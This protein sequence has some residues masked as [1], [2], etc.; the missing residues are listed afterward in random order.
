MAIEQQSHGS[1]DTCAVIRYAD[2]GPTVSWNHEMFTSK[3]RIERLAAYHDAKL[4]AAG[5]PVGCLTV[6]R[7]TEPSTAGYMV[8]KPAAA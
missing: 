6:F 1:R 4:R 5:K 8:R 3:P 2:A 7:G